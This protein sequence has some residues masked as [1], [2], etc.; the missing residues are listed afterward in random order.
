MQMVIPCIQFGIYSISQTFAFPLKAE[1]SSHQIYDQSF[2][3]FF[4]FKSYGGYTTASV[5]GQGDGLF[6]CG[7]SVAPVTDW[8]Y[9]GN[10]L[11]KIDHVID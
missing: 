3:F 6:E 7:I 4:L 10:I 2:L 8:H 9:Y 11:M 5:I 1:R